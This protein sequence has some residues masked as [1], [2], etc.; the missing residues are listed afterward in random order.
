MMLV[1]EEMST[2][3]YKMEAM[4]IDN[5]RDVSKQMIY[6]SLLKRWS[7]KHKNYETLMGRFLL[8]LWNTMAILKMAPMPGTRGILFRMSP[9][10]DTQITSNEWTI[11]LSRDAK[12]EGKILLPAMKMNGKLSYSAKNGETVLKTLDFNTMID[13]PSGHDT[14]KVKA[15]LTMGSAGEKEMQMCYEAMKT[16]TNDRA[17]TNCMF[18]IN[19]EGEA[20]CVKGEAM[21]EGTM[22]SE[23]SEEQME[24]PKY[25][26]CKSP[27]ITEHRLHH[28][29]PC[30]EAYNS[31]RKTTMKF[32]EL[33]PMP[34]EYKNTMDCIMEMMRDVS[35][36]SRDRMGEMDTIRNR[37][38]IMMPDNFTLEMMM[39]DMPIRP[40]NTLF[41]KMYL[42]MKHWGLMRHCYVEGKM[43]KMN[44]TMLK[45]EVP[46]DWLKLV[47][48]TAE[49]TDSNAVY[50]KRMDD[51]RLVSLINIFSVY[52]I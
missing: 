32:K 31:L 46:K 25:A 7:G 47:S 5:E 9:M 36:A 35:S 1:N 13:L 17:V 40:A 8:S 42:M 10:S 45:D 52:F 19:K 43:I 16:W 50:V 34:K 41:G 33:R 6:N 22:I 49:Q 48:D 15:Q 23:K 11:R 20:K 44:N 26:E 12:H 21:M 24:R 28:Y 18:D 2:L 27:S 39:M 38:E 29:V 3:G 37:L 14:M 4:L 30:Y 51:D